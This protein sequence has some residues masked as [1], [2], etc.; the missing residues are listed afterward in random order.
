MLNKVVT[1]NSWRYIS[2]AM[3][4]IDICSTVEMSPKNIF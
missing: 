2:I 1:N 3:N 4:I